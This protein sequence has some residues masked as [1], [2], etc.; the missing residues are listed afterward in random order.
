MNQKFHSLVYTQDNR[1]ICLFKNLYMNVHTKII[2]DSLQVETMQ[3]TTSWWINKMWYIFTVQY[4]LDT[5][6]DE[7]SQYCTRGK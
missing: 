4:N 1:N 5:K 7:P 3:M 2:H 6:I